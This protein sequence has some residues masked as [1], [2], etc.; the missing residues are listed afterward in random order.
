[1][2]VIYD[3]RRAQVTD[4]SANVLGAQDVRMH[5]LGPGRLFTP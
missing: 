3:A 1:V 5:I 4:V 2:V